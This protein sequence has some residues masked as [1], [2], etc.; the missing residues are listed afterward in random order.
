MNKC[1]QEIGRTK[2]FGPP[3]F[4]HPLSRSLRSAFCSPDHPIIRS[5]GGQQPGGNK[6]QQF[7]VGVLD[8]SRLKEIPE[9]RDVS[10]HR[11][12]GGG[13]LALRYRNPAKHHRPPIRHKD[14]SGR[15]LQINAH[16]GIS[17]DGPWTSVLHGNAQEDVAV[18]GDLRG[19]GELQGS[20][21]ILH[22]NGVVD[23]SLNGNLRALLDHPLSVVLGDDARA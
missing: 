19:D 11:Y 2:T 20:V 9:D 16:R 10:K 17:D 6:E 4:T 23:A 1:H 14:L 3:P 13:V 21:R 18:V 5:L 8:V 22:R 12:L 15:L 7:L